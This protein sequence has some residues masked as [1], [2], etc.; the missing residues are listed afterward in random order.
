MGIIAIVVVITTKL[1]RV[2][3]HNNKEQ[4]VAMSPTLAMMEST[5]S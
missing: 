1:A 5:L 4:R 3:K 2:A